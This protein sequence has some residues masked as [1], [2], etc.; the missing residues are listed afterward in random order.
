MC[1]VENLVTYVH[2]W[3]ERLHMCMREF[4]VTYVT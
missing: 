1:M 2:N 4:W 3:D